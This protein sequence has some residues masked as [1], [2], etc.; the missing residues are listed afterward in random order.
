MG[1]IKLYIIE[2]VDLLND[3]APWLLLGFLIAGVLHVFFPQ[4]K[5]EQILGAKS[6]R[7]LLNATL[8]GIPLP[9]CSCGV[10]PTGIS[11]FR[12]GASKGSAV[13]F[14]ISTP[15]TGV[16]S[17]MVTYSLL[18]L[19]FALLRPVVALVTG[20]FGGLITNISDIK[21]E[22]STLK[23]P[24]KGNNMNNP[25]KS[26][27]YRMLNYA[28]VEF[29]Q[30]IVKW[31]IIGLLIAALFA[32]VIP[33]DFFSTYIKSN[34]IGMLIILAASIP[35]Y[36][37]ATSS[38]PIAAILLLK[39]ISPGAALVF[40]MAGPATNAATITVIGNTMGRKTLITYMATLIVGAL[41]FGFL[42]DNFIPGDFIMKGISRV[43]SSHEHGLLPY[44]LKVSSGIIMVIL[45]ANVYIQRYLRKRK[46][47]AA[48]SDESKKTKKTQTMKEFKIIVK[49]MTCG[50]CKMNI[51][52][53]IKQLAG[54]EKVSADVEK[55][56]VTINADNID[57]EKV[58]SAVESTGYIY[59][60]M[61]I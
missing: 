55:G 8:I 43:H 51:E 17:I 52:R 56:E 53:S 35:V 23:S 18:G 15:Q 46:E 29:L 9:L 20:F 49:G 3:M 11:F 5:I 4:K 54:I 40:L 24:H 1:Y 36:V 45:F 2:L 39:G 22:P 34:I 13:S 42:V 14:M 30:D 41:T 47:K 6:T 44:W 60:G 37:C 7:S 59:K 61:I 32:V 27:V 38:V 16:D 33:D 50:H 19:P 12:N 31:L 58:K 57:L 28:F 26:P 21:S 25:A 10:I 48:P